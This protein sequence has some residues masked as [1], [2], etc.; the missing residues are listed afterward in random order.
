MQRLMKVLLAA[1][2]LLLLLPL[3]HVFPLF[4]SH[5]ASGAPL[6]FSSLQSATT[7]ATPAN[8]P[9]TKPLPLAEPTPAPAPAPA[10]SL[11]GRWRVKFALTD[12][13]EKH[14]IFEPNADGSGS[15]QLLDTGPDDKPVAAPARAIWSQLT[16][17]RVSFSGELELPLGTCCREIGTLTF[18]GKFTSRDTISGR[19]VFV[20]SVEEEENPNKF[21]SKVGTFTA[22]RVPN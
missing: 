4:H 18:K 10:N 11:P 16:N 1:L 12:D 8:S 3:F 22:V 13:P 21:R 6:P 2:F 5:A 14:L 15:F 7:S 20:T 19:L 17:D 9:A